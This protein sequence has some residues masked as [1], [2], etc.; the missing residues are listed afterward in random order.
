MR[1]SAAN[2][3]A[4]SDEREDKVPYIFLRGTPAKAPVAAPV[5]RAAQSAPLTSTTASA[6]RATTP[7]TTSEDRVATPATQ[8]T[9]RASSVRATLVIVASEPGSVASVIS[10]VSS[11]S[12]LVIKARV[13][14][15]LHLCWVGE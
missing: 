11:G 2:V 4:E 10:R 6:G 9:A 7:V 12:G 13:K 14:P 1:V 15:Y 3:N 5:D 8:S